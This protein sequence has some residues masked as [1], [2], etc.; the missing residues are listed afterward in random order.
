MGRWQTPSV[1]QHLLVD[2]LSFGRWRPSS[3]FSSDTKWLLS[4]ARKEVTTDAS[5]THTWGLRGG[6]N[7]LLIPSAG[8]MPQSLAGGMEGHLLGEGARNLLGVAVDGVEQP[9]ETE[10][11]NGS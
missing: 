2:N 5:S 4:A 1:R 11:K 10:A 7:L 3:Y 8:P 9:G 6:R